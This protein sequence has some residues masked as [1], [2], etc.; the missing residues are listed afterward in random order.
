MITF[1]SLV[2][3]I[4]WVLSGLS[5]GFNDPDLIEMHLIKDY[6][7]KNVILFLLKIYS[8]FK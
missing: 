5:L 1:L 4:H 6:F 7:G 2:S 3:V 8:L